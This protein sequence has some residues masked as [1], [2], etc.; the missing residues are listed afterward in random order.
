ML[1]L[2]KVTKWLLLLSYVGLMAS[3]GL[4]RLDGPLMG[5][6]PLVLLSISAFSLA[7]ICESLLR[8]EKK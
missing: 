2:N 4:Q 8:R 3:L 5:N 6:W 7:F 1:A